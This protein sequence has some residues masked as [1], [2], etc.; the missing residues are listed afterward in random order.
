MAPAKSSLNQLSEAFILGL[1][2]DFS[3]TSHTILRTIDK[4]GIEEK[5][6]QLCS[7]CG[8]YLSHEEI[9]KIMKNYK[10][11]PNTCA[12]CK[13]DKVTSEKGKEHISEETAKCT[14]TPSVIC[15]SCS[16]LISETTN[17][18]LPP[19]VLQNSQQLRYEVNKEK[20]REQIKEFLIEDEE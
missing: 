3:H 10:N 17:A 20:L 5:V 9:E 6:G 11:K 2:E 19:Y 12:D 8:S 4:L 14:V 13:C 7:V 1:Q 16:I 15:Y 18:Q